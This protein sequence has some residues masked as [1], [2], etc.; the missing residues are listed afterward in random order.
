MTENES[1]SILDEDLSSVDTS[2]PVLRGNVI[3]DFEIVNIEVTKSKDGLGDVLR[4]QLKTTGELLSTKN[5]TVNAGWT[6][7]NYISLSPKGDYTIDRIRRSLAQFVEAVEG[8]PGQ[9]NPTDR[10]IGKRVRCKVK[11]TKPTAEYPNEG[12]SVS[13]VKPA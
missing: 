11:V 5:D 8:R 10:F 2:M 13:W 7:Y 12:N 1:L 9:V 6:L 4:I 3:H